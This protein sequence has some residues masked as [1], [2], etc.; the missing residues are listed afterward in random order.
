MLPFNIRSL[1]VK[2]CIS[3]LH[4]GVIAETNLKVCQAIRQNIYCTEKKLIKC[5]LNNHRA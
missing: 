2:L 1:L 3:Y 4:I 5:L